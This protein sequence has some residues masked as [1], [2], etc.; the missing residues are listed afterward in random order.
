MA[1]T[2][3]FKQQC[4]SCEA[5]VPIR[6]PG[7][8]GKKIDCPKCKYRFV[9]EEPLPEDDE[10]GD[11]G[12]AEGK[13]TKS[14]AV[15]DKKGKPRRLRDDEIP[16]DEDE[17]SKGKSKAPNPKVLY[18]GIGLGVVA[19]VA[20]IGGGILLFGGGS[21]PAAGGG[22]GGGAGPAKANTAPVVVVGQPTQA[23]PVEVE[24]PIDD[25]TN[26]LPNETAVLVGIDPDKVINSSVKRSMLEIPGAFTDA[27]FKRTFDFNLENVKRLLTAVLPGEKPDE[28]AFFSVMQTAKPFNQDYLKKSLKLTALPP[29]NG[30]DSFTVNG[31]LDTLS[32]LFLRLSTPPTQKLTVHFVDAVTLVFADAA[33]MKKF[34]DDKRRPSQLTQP[35]PPPPDAP[36]GP[37][38]G[39]NAPSPINPGRP[40]GGRG[41][42]GA[43]AH[44]GASLPG[45]A[46]FQQPGPGNGIGD[47]AG[48]GTAPAPEQG[49]EA[50]PTASGSYLTVDPSLKIAIDRIERD[51]VPP[52]VF[53]AAFLA[54]A[55]MMPPELTSLGAVD[56]A[57]ID[58]LIPRVPM[59]QGTVVV[60]AAVQEFSEIKASGLVV[61]QSSNTENARH[62]KAMI[63]YA[64]E[65]ASDL[66]RTSW[67]IDIIPGVSNGKPAAGVFPRAQL[68]GRQ[69]GAPNQSQ[70]AATGKDGSITSSIREK[71]VAVQ[72]DVNLASSRRLYEQVRDGLDA[73]MVQMKGLGELVGSRPRIHELARALQAYTKAKNAFPRGALQRPPSSE[74]GIDWYPDQRLSWMVELLPYLGDG[75]FKDLLYEADKSW[76]EGTNLL[77]AQ[78]L[79]PQFLSP[80]DPKRAHV[81]YPGKVGLFAATRFVGVAGLGLDAATYPAANASF[82]KKI[83]VFGYDRVTKT[84]DIHDEAEST[85]AILQIPSGQIAPW[86]AGGG[87]TIRGIPEGDDA[88]KAFICTEY[89]GKKGTI[90]VMADGKVRFI[91]EDMKPATFRALCTI[92]GGER[93]EDINELAPLVPEETANDSKAEQPASPA[94]VPPAKPDSTAPPA[95]E[96][97]PVAAKTALPAGWKE[98]VD[99]AAGCAVALPPGTSTTP[100]VP[101]LPGALA[102]HATGVTTANGSTFAIWQFK[103][104]IPVPTTE[105]P[106][107]FEAV[108]TRL[109][110]DGKISA[111]KPIELD[112]NK[113][114]EW[115]SENPATGK[116]G[117]RCYSVKDQVYVLRSGGPKADWKDVQTFLDS[118]RLLK[119]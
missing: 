49:V 46:L 71:T 3:S 9:V 18:I 86:M 51:K 31:D 76:S 79:I 8:V 97:P 114:M 19:L 77:T 66:L 41:A 43:N 100:P 40:K 110:R 5:M 60:G 106:R 109:L 96:A 62:A 117:T 44:D 105:L 6:D 89:K 64:A 63:D 15:T 54:K 7:L 34:L 28:A 17:E 75:E 26:L 25:I 4:P 21:K 59:P 118:F 29:V 53:V 102:S 111:E 23:A 78:V 52:I 84:E 42:P 99:E 45:V 1:T 50:E 55:K 85:I 95:S 24:A 98:L 88:L 39:G 12:A 27:T 65:L 58:K 33:P 11:D 16:P 91:A 82:A 72:I 83:G 93:L 101:E 61:L 38:G 92:A 115:I 116:T 70:M 14:T 56:K 30:F 35:P 10:A 81:H 74:R 22:G 57:L 20:L 119:K 73:E 36:Q 47:I 108:K 68:G 80:G 107:V 37:P 103:L 69:P 67:E 48:R 112:G 32:D 94:T 2:S 113:G 87:A 104:G 13:K 90:A